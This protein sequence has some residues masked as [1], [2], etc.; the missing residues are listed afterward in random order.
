METQ[1]PYRHIISLRWLQLSTLHRP[2][3]T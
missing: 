3:V 2:T 1:Q